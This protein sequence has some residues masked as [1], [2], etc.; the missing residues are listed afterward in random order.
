MEYQVST[1]TLSKKLS[2]DHS[3]S[4]KSIYDGVFS[5]PP[6]NFRAPKF[7]SRIEDYS[8]IFGSGSSGASRGSSIPILDIP[9]LNERNV[10]VDAR[11]SKLDYSNVFGGFGEFDFA[12]SYEELISKPKKKSNG[13]SE[14]AR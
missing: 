11:G 8:E 4:S 10:S 1:A 6:S 3:F 14:K 9:A 2:K 12:V 5:T 7:S 13:F